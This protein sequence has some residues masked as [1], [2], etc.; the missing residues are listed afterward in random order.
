MLK[1]PLYHDGFRTDTLVDT[2]ATHSYI[3]T[4]LAKKLKLRFD[5]LRN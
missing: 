4:K 5:E 3:D 1:V 2:G